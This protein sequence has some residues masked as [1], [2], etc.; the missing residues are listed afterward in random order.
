[1]SVGFF[2]IILILLL[3]LLLFGDI[4]KILK[5]VASGITTFKTIVNEDKDKSNINK[6]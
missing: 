4:P 5:N 3:I 6:N 2:Q 1:M